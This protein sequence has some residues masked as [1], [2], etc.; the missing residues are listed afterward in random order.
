MVIS[1]RHVATLSARSTSGDLMGEHGLQWV[2]ASRSISN[3]ACVELAHDGDLI[4]LRNSRDP[5]RVL[6]YTLDELAAFLDGA[7]RGEF[8]HLLENE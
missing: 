5:G 3:G 1:P 8:D 6:H 4:A 7:K 2:K